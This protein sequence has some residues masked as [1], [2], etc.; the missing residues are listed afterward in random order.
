MIITMATTTITLNPNNIKWLDELGRKLS[1]KQNR[2]QVVEILVEEA[3]KHPE[4]F[5]K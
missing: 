4:R 3:K 1:P 5:N 2:S